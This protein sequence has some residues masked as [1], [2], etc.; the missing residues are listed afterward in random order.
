MTAETLNIISLG[1]RPKP[2]LARTQ[3]LAVLSYAHEMGVEPFL[4]PSLELCLA[5]MEALS[6]QAAGVATACWGYAA[7][8]GLR[9]Q[10]ERIWVQGGCWLVRHLGLFASQ[11][12]G[13]CQ[14]VG[15]GAV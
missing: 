2:T 11:F 4:E 6:Q 3:V 13:R 14:A 9:L 12:Q 8:A 7:H 15:G 1:L 10:A 5:L